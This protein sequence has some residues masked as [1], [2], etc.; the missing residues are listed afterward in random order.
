MAA[1]DLASM[2]FGQL[3][4]FHCYLAVHQHI[5]DR[6]F[7]GVDDDLAVFGRMP[8]MKHAGNRASERY[9]SGI[10]DNNACSGQLQIEVVE[11][12]GHSVQGDQ[13]IELARI[14]SDRL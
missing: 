13:P 5:E 9:H 4:V 11:G 7:I 3:S 12:S 2:R 14:L 6:D 1:E 8:I 10:S